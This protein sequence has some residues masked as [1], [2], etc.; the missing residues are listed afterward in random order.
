MLRIKAMKGYVELSVV[1][2]Y[3][4]RL[5]KLIF[6]KGIC[7]VQMFMFR[8]LLRVFRQ[9]P[10]VK[11]GSP[12]AGAPS[13]TRGSSHTAFVTLFCHASLV[14]HASTFDQHARCLGQLCWGGRI[15]R[16]YGLPTTPDKE[17]GND[18]QKIGFLILLP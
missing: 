1:S 18:M 9:N 14:E 11:A 12:V 17:Y 13:T 16:S 6:L 15:L 3:G 5:S 4:C 2:M 8:R 10:P 7:S